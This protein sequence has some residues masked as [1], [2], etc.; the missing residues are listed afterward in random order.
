VATTEPPTDQDF[1][2]P[3][4]TYN[5]WFTE[6][7]RR[8]L[9]A[10][11][12]PLA[13]GNMEPATHAEAARAL[14]LHPNTARNVLYEVWDLLRAKGVPLPDV[15]EKRIAVIQA[16]RLHRLLPPLHS[17]PAGPPSEPVAP[18]TEPLITGRAVVTFS[19]PHSYES[20]VLADGDVAEFGRGRR[21]EVRFA[22]G[23]MADYG[24]PRVAGCLVV[25]NRRVF[26]EV[27]DAA[28]RP[29]IEVV[30]PGRPP[31]L[32]AVGDGFSPAERAFQVLV[33]GTSQKW[34]LDVRVRRDPPPAETEPL[35][36]ADDP[37]LGPN[38][39]YN[40]WFTETQRRVLDAYRE[41]LAR[42]R[43]EP[44]THAEAA[45]ALSLHPNTARNVIYDI[46]ALLFAEGVP[47]PDIAEKRIAVIEAI[48]LHRLLPPLGPTTPPGDAGRGQR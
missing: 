29:S 21:C 28:G 6:A 33:P 7:Q 9:D 31:E 8:V 2:G 5:I 25:A 20:I 46:W 3:T 36:T 32:I 37:A 16:I 27:T 12:E 14:S 34:S 19:A 39:T 26:V 45:R 35:A 44:A 30:T 11:R 17:T 18:Q 42:G 38:S 24:V 1:S 22:Y 13:R 41:P 40:I 15:A 47:L 10:Y 23:P 43:K 48:R 4:R